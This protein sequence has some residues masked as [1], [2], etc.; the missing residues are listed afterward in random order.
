MED[1]AMANDTVT[2]RIDPEL[3][4]EAEGIFKAI[5]LRTSEAIR[6][7]LQQC[8]NTGG[9]PFQ[10]QTKQPNTETLAAI[11]ELENCGGKKF[12]NTDEF[13]KDLG[14]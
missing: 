8:V 2:A 3:K 4:S 5:G 7:F 12:D 14:I 10:P 11:K 1:I 6:L 13:Y 9:L